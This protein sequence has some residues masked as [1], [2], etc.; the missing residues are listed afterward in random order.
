MSR[1]PRKG[2]ADKAAETKR[3]LLGAAAKVVGS[4]GYANASVAKITALA[5]VAQGTFYNYF[6]SQQDLFDHLLPEL[7]GELLDFIRERLVGIEDSYEREE[8]G[9][10]AFFEFL[11]QRPEFYRILN[12]AETFSPTAFRDH[13]QNMAAGYSR[14]LARSQSK[15]EMRG[16][17]AR[18]IEVVVYTLLSARNYLAYHYAMRDN[19]ARQLPAWVTAAY[20]KLVGGGMQLGTRARQPH[21][22]RAKV[23]PPKSSGPAKL[24]YTILEQTRGRV[25]V[26]L[27]IEDDDREANACV[28]LAV[29]MEML[30]YAGAL[31]A[32][33]GADK[34]EVHLQSMS[35]S[36]IVPASAD[37]LVALA[38]TEGGERTLHVALRLADAAR[39][40]EPILTAQAVY[41]TT[42]QPMA[43]VR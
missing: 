6:A 10:R 21:R 23:G 4:E 42:T 31:A 1:R 35:L 34:G 33:E 8:A 14:S 39:P 25:E 12:E 40:D 2:R 43:T 30:E 7:G 3:R 38:R 15:G 26:E 9:F 24:S 27:D 32:S 20:M 17:E 37:R 13:M 5:E 28:R 18:E 11:A 29:L 22:Q 41:A 36:F 16:F 19:R